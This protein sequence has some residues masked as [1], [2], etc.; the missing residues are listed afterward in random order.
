MEPSD[1]RQRATRAAEA[2]AE[3]FVRIRDELLSATE[4][5][6]YLDWLR[7]SPRNV[8]EMLRVW[9]LYGQ[10]RASKLR[11]VLSHEDLLSGIVDR[12]PP[13]GTPV[14]RPL[15]VPR[16]RWRLAAL[17]IAIVLIAALG[18]VFQHSML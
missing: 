11:A 3:W 13:P 10:L 14:P 8:A 6:E 9:R 16:S 17:V 15:R 7:Q 18:L 5:R 2:A 1:D 4:R 12:Y